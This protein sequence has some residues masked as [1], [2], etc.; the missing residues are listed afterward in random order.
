MSTHEYSPHTVQKAGL[1]VKRGGFELWYYHFMAVFW[2][3]SLSLL[4]S[5][6]PP[7]EDGINDPSVMELPWRWNDMSVEGQEDIIRAVIGT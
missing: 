2:G 6:F 4:K 1:N 3:K 5:Q 7:L